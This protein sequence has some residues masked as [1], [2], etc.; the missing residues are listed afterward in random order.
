MLIKS[1]VG[2]SLLML[3]LCVLRLIKKMEFEFD[4][5]NLLLLSQLNFCG[6]IIVISNKMN[7]TQTFESTLLRKITTK[8]PY[9]YKNIKLNST[10]CIDL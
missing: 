1:S 2:Y 8:L 6:K 10:C 3:A 4:N 5:R 7:I 9:F